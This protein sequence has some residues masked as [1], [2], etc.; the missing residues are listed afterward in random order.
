MKMSEDEN[1][2]ERT[3]KI[4]R[5]V[6]YLANLLNP[7]LFPHSDL[8]LDDVAVSGRSDMEETLFDYKN[9]VP[10][11]EKMMG[12]SPSGPNSEYNSGVELD[13][14]TRNLLEVKES[15]VISDFFYNMEKFIEEAK[16]KKKDL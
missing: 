15:S 3:V 7:V 2:T 10:S 6:S 12:V 14:Y 4:I 8:E 5:S 13:D 9:F 1:T 11:Y 16:K